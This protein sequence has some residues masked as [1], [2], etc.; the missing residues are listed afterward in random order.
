M[1]STV[2]KDEFFGDDDTT[3]DFFA[4]DFFTTER[5]PPR[6]IISKLNSGNTDV[7]KVDNR[8]R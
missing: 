6:T 1:S 4:D 2:V 8:L 3:K 5:L 7:S